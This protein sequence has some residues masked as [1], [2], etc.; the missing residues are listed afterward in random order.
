MS[1]FP[2]PPR[3]PYIFLSKPEENFEKYNY[4]TISNSGADSYTS[5]RLI[6]YLNK[7]CEQNEIKI[8]DLFISG[9]DDAD[10]YNCNHDKLWT[11][12]YKTLIVNKTYKSAL[13][14]YEKELI[15]FNKDMEEYNK[16]E[17]KYQDEL[18]IYQVEEAKK[19]IANAEKKKK[20]IDKQVAE[21]KKKL[22]EQ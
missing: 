22:K 16:L 13:K 5:H 20:Q 1:K 14:K 18:E 21:A 17:K 15:K 4:L 19:I 11:V 2:T 12:Y 3:K 7:F 10:D 9:S 8:D 6:D